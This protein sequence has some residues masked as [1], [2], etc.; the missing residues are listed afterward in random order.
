MNPAAAAEI[1]RC[2]AQCRSPVGRETDDLVE[3]V[4]EADD[5]LGP[6]IDIAWNPCSGALR[7]LMWAWR[8]RPVGDEQFVLLF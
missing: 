7:F 2:D 8:H 4:A 5:A 6:H 3:Q 1:D